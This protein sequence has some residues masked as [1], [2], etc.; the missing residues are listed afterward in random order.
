MTP[1]SNMIDLTSGETLSHLPPEKVF[2]LEKGALRLDFV[3]GIGASSLIGMVLAGDYV[4]LDVLADPA[5]DLRYRA[6]TP[7]QLAQV[8]V[9]AQ[10]LNEIMLHGLVTARLRS[11]DMVQLRSGTV[12]DRVRRLFVMI[13]SD[14]ATG[15][16]VLQSLPSLK[17][18]ADL[19]GSAPETISRAI[20]QLK[21][22]D[23]VSERRR[24]QANLKIDHLTAHQFERANRSVFR[25][26]AS[27]GA[28]PVGA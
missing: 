16:E 18:M 9:S 12:V 22:L 14:E 24:H 11:R 21:C 15:Q 1:L 10:G 3:D 8:Q 23:M 2:R 17:E 5:I 6:I 26:N 13:A 25:P 28:V 4:G 7:C 19:L 20:S 27:S